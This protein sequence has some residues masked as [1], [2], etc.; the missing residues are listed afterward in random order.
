MIKPNKL[1]VSL[2]LLAAAL[3]TGNAMA[4]G[5]SMRAEHRLGANVYWHMGAAPIPSAKG[6]NASFYASPKWALGVD[7]SSA[8]LGFKFFG[9]DVAAVHETK[10]AIEARRFVG[11][12]FNMQFGFGHRTTQGRVPK[13]WID[14]AI[15]ETSETVSEMKANY[16]SFG[17]GNQ[18]QFG[19]RYTFAVDWFKLEVPVWA[20]VTQSA[21]R[22]AKDDATKSDIEETESILRWY[23]SG[24]TLK[25]QIGLLF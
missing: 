3:S 10:A 24:G 12:S 20:E 5:S 2:T 17:I 18:W 6:F 1:L 13:D 8:T 25:F 14:V 21:S 11:N 7:Y 15:G 4:S 16:V 22:Y 19:S 23:P 9:V